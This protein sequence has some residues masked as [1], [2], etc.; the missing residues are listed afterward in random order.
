[1]ELE[2][3]LLSKILKAACN[4]GAYSPQLGPSSVGMFIFFKSIS[5]SFVCGVFVFVAL[6]GLTLVDTRCP[7]VGVGWVG[8]SQEG[9]YT[10]ENTRCPNGHL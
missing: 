9:A 8:L 3:L 5:C 6:K 2:S 1:M 7:K 10:S 4:L